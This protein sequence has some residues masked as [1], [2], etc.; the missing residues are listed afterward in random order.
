M[1][2]VFIEGPAQ[3]PLLVGDQAQLAAVLSDPSAPGEISWASSD[4]AVALVDDRGYLRAQRPG[5]ATIS[6]HLKKASSQVAITVLPRT[7]GYTTDEVDYLQEIAFGFEYGSASE[8][9]RKWGE[10]P[11]L[12]IFGTPTQQDLTVLE[13]LISDLNALMAEVQVELVDSDPTVEVHFAEVAVFPSILPSYVPG[14]TGYFSIWFNELEQ[15]YRSVVLIASDEGDQE[16][17]SHILREEV[18]QMLGL[19]R[20]SWTYMSSIFYQGWTTTQEY[21]PI[22]EALIEMLYRPELPRGAAYRPAVD[23]L[24]TLT[25]QGWAGVAAPVRGAAEN[26]ALTPADRIGP[27]GRVGRAGTGSGGG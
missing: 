6:A 10:N 27:S 9:I 23:I 3:A 24:R 4:T 5:T 12:K 7:G 19:G 13:S 11:R 26:E 1:L 16:V 18:T 15:I 8:V 20:D 17:R 2:E 25:R 22:D 14:N 21:A